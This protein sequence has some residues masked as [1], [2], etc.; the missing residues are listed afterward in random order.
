MRSSATWRASLRFE[1]QPVSR[2]CA[3]L[4][5]IGVERYLALYDA[6]KVEPLR[7]LL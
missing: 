5:R 4:I 3:G 2:M 7:A 6:T 1:G